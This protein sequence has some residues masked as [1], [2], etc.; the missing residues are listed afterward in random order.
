MTQ[1]VEL[2]LAAQ[3]REI[4]L[5]APELAKEQEAHDNALHAE[6]EAE[7]RLLA[8]VAEA[9]K[10]ALPAIAGRI[11]FFPRWRGV[12]LLDG[13][14]SN[15]ARG[16][17]VY[18]L[19]D[20]SFAETWRTFRDADEER[21]TTGTCSNCKFVCATETRKDPNPTGMFIM[22]RSYSSAKCIVR[23]YD[24]QP[25]VSGLHA[26]MKRQRGKRVPC[27][28]EAQK[29]TAKLNAILTLLG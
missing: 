3:A 27:T 18:L 12:L 19:E 28:V 9:A 20:G 17:R 1:L 23:S 25:L 22:F 26:E 24:P 14:K 11:E 2:Q 29:T 15:S 7:A 5:L 16:R 6:R 13:W 4:R 21:S 10:P 8:H